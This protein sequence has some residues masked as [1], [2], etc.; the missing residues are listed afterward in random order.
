M[1]IQRRLVRMLFGRRVPV[2]G[3]NNASTRRRD[4]HLA[5][6]LHHDGAL[7]LPGIACHCSRYFSLGDPTLIL[8]VHITIPFRQSSSFL[9]F[10]LSLLFAQLT[11]CH[12]RWIERSTVLLFRLLLLR[13]LL[14]LKLQRDDVRGRGLRAPHTCQATPIHPLRKGK[15]P[16]SETLQCTHVHLPFIP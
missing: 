7:L 14:L 4:S 2:R 10:F 13:L 16:V 1:R 8:S 6:P 11:T 3:E 15:C 9:P 12:A 5:S